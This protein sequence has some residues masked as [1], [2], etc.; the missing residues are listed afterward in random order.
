MTFIA[1]SL[2]FTFATLANDPF[3]HPIYLLLKM[4]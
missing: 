2:I 1:D 4:D 3:T